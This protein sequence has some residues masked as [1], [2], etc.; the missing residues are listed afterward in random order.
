[1][2]DIGVII[3]A[4]GQGTRMKSALPKVMHPVAGRPML[5]HVLATS[6]SLDPRRVIVVT[7]PGQDEVRASC[8]GIDFAIQDPPSGT[9]HAV[10]AAAKQM[11]GFKG[12]V[13]ILFAADPLVRKETIDRM[14]AA[15]H[16]PAGRNGTDPAVVVL[17]FRPKDPAQYG[18]LIVNGSG[19]LEE[20]VE[21]RDASEEVRKVGLCNSG[22][23]VADGAI[24]F[25]L[26]RE[27]KN[28]NAKKEYYLTDI[29]AIARRRNLPSVVVEGE[30][31]E[32]LGVNSRDELALVEAVMQKRLRE[33]AMTEGATLQDPSTVY[34]SHDT[35]LGRDVTVGPNVVFG[36]GVTV[37]DNVTI[38][39][40]CHLEGATIADGAIIG[41]FARLRPGADISAGAHVGN[42][43]E[44]KNAIIGEGAKANHLSYIGDAWVG[45]GANIGAGTITCNYDG[46][47]KHLTIIGAGAFIG[48]N[49]TLVPPV[50]VDDGAYTGAG[51]VITKDV[52]KDGFAVTRAEQINRPEA[53]ARYRQ[54]KAAEKSSGN[55]PKPDPKSVK[56]NR[57]KD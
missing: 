2:S 14:L 50:T 54:R 46:F 20:I 12:D 25:D 3:L 34:F 31:E 44:I 38:N 9:G 35:K 32:V 5:H 57:G 30:E 40:F 28:D 42:F 4:A 24:L 45:P 43:V 39:A 52:A 11:D 1:M 18:R 16:T 8:P 41:P 49:S 23:M 13:V 37:G 15:R 10:L 56:R 48:S 19:V 6:R 22:V 21:F 55:V 29:I 36:P 47:N 7:S 33:K 26:L 53:A 17:G 51:S 27:V